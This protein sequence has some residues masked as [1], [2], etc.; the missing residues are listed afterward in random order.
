M[1]RRTS[2]ADDVGFFRAM[3]DTLIA[4]GVVERAARLHPCNGGE[5]LHFAEANLKKFQNSSGAVMSCF[6]GP[7][8]VSARSRCIGQPWPWPS[9]V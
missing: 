2:D 7:V 9:I 4:E 8:P 1:K 3:F 5:G 6:F